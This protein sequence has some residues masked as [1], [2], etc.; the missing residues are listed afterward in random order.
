MNLIGVELRFN[1]LSDLIEGAGID[2][3]QVENQKR[4]LIHQVDLVQVRVE[5]V[6][7]AVCVDSKPSGMC[8][9][10]IAVELVGFLY[11][12]GR[13]SLLGLDEYKRNAIL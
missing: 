10:E 8:S 7:D 12:Q 13:S 2:I 1:E 6:L 9:S 3:Q 5:E 11:M 4:L